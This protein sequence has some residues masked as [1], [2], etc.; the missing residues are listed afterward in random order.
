M[1][2]GLR[3]QASGFELMGVTAREEK[4]YGI[5]WSR[6]SQ[7]LSVSRLYENPYTHRLLYISSIVRVVNGGQAYA[8]DIFTLVGRLSSGALGLAEKQIKR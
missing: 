2:R 7:R 3:P 4:D 8:N 5:M 6:L 1:E